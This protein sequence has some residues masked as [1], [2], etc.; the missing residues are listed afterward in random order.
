MDV[1]VPGL[2]RGMLFNPRVRVVD[3]RVVGFG[4]Q[5]QKRKDAVKGQVRFVAVYEP[6]PCGFFYRVSLV[7]P[8]F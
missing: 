5:S 2:E 8:K 4:V 6:A 7:H 1:Q 3:S